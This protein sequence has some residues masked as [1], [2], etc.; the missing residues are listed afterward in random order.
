M[1]YFKILSADGTVKSVEAL[2]DPSTSV[3]RPATAFLS[4][5]TNGTR[6]ASCP[7]RREH[8]LSASGEAAKRR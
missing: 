8:N 2:A 3:G 5:A 4:G 7:A 6:R 1:V